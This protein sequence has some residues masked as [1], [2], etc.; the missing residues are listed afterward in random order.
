MLV[1]NG[2]LRFTSKC[3]AQCDFAATAKQDSTKAPFLINR[4]AR[5]IHANAVANDQGYGTAPKCTNNMCNNIALMLHGCTRMSGM[6][7]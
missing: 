7:K 4:S 3:C 5:L 1:N 6:Y 2:S